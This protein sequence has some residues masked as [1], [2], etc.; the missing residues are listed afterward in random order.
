M[1]LGTRAQKSEV[2]A[3]KKG[4]VVCR[5]PYD[6]D[7]LPHLAFVSHAQ[8][9]F[10]LEVLHGMEELLE[11]E[12][13]FHLQTWMGNHVIQAAALQYVP[14]DAVVTTGWEWQSL[15]NLPKDTPVIGISNAKVEAEFPRC[16]NDDVAV[17]RVAAEAMLDAGYERLLLLKN[18][19]LHHVRLRCQGVAE[20]AK[21]HQLPLEVRDISLRR[22]RTGESFGEVLAETRRV[23]S[24]LVAG[25][26]PG[27]GVLAVQSDAAS[28]FLEVFENESPLKIPGEIGM[29]VLDLP[30]PDE[31]RLAYVELNGREI[32][33]RA[34]RALHDQMRGVAPLAPG[35]IVAVPPVGIRHGQTL[36]QGEG[37]LLHQKL[38]QYY[39][40]RLAEEIGVE[41]VA[42]ALGHSRRSLEMKLKA[43]NLPAPYVLLTRLRLQRAEALLAGGEMSIEDIAQECG[44]ANA[45]SLTERFRAH[46]GM[47]PFAYRKKASRGAQAG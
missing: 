18:L 3:K 1:N 9:R 6:G 7:M 41:S 38:C 28:M 8:N 24:A 27:T 2:F 29:L 16:V 46:H 33:R 34:V 43:C 45:R 5:A 10:Y 4:C 26:H 30:P 22:P 11:E 35:S 21:Q 42:R 23:M 25:L 44:F 47:T 37:V 15:S 32:A 14:V 31:A 12:G 13:L 39:Q 17:G 36:R 40:A 19:D 20:S